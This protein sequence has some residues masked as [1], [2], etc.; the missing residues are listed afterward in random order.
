MQRRRKISNKKKKKSTATIQEIKNR[1]LSHPRNADL[2]VTSLLKCFFTSWDNCHGLPL[3]KKIKKKL[4]KRAKTKL[5]IK[6]EG[7]IIKQ[8]YK[9]YPF[10]H[11]RFWL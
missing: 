7:V 11:I 10:I 4:C 6:G 2:V 9:V 1:R 5:R 3:K 8:A